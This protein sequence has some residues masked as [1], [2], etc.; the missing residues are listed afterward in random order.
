MKTFTN[1]DIQL[2][3]SVLLLPSKLRFAST[4]LR[5]MVGT[6]HRRPGQHPVESEGLPDPLPTPDAEQ[7]HRG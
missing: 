4:V 1:Y 5:R 6:S 7:R 2:L 3:L